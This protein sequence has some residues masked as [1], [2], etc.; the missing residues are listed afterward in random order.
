MKRLAGMERPK[1]LEE[2]LNPDPLKKAAREL[3]DHLQILQGAYNPYRTQPF[4]LN[5]RYARADR[6]FNDNINSHP[7]GFAE[8]YKKAVEA[9]FLDAY[10]KDGRVRYQSF[11][12]SASNPDGRVRPAKFDMAVRNYEKKYPATGRE[13]DIQPVDSTKIDRLS[14]LLQG[15][16]DGSRTSL[17]SDATEFLETLSRNIKLHL[18]KSGDG[19][20]TKSVHYAMLK[21]LDRL[22]ADSIRAGV[23]SPTPFASPAASP[24]EQAISDTLRG[25]SGHVETLAGHAGSHAAALTASNGR[26]DRIT[27]ALKRPSDSPVRAHLLQ[28]AAQAREYGFQITDH[29]K[30]MTDH[31]RSSRAGTTLTFNDAEEKHAFADEHQ[32]IFTTATHIRDGSVKFNNVFRNVLGAHIDKFE[33]IC[34]REPNKDRADNFSGHAKGL[35]EWFR[36]VEK[37]LEMGEFYPPAK[38]R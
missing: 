31:W 29:L 16:A 20:N 25:I 2:R 5:I 26:L 15:V 30:L 13:G 37:Q 12:E 6:Y 1:H 34:N 28:K 38:G 21:K 19:P 10:G 9:L 35:V 22:V 7:S 17:D 32:R 27:E 8:W 23:L 11:L 36:R 24:Y 4:D 3:K 33:E 14:Q 18:E